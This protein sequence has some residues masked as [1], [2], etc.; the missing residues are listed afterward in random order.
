MWWARSRRAADLLQRRVLQN[1][2]ETSPARRDWCS[3]W[4]S[5]NGAYICLP[6]LRKSCDPSDKVHTL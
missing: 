5:R 6:G 2:R 1:K 4:E 3:K